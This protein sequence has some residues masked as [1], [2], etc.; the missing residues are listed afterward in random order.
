MKSLLS[1]QVGRVRFCLDIYEKDH[2]IEELYIYKAMRNTDLGEWSQVHKI[3]HL[4][5]RRLD[6]RGSTVLYLWMNE[7]FGFDKSKEPL[8]ICSV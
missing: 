2:K 3:E 7:Y 1:K 5:H 6:N 8:H 4:V